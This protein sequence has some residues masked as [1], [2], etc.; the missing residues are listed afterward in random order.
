M[1][2]TDSYI[3]DDHG[4]PQRCDDLLVWAR[5]METATRVVEQTR[6]DHPFPP[7]DEQIGCFTSG[8]VCRSRDLGHA[9]TSIDLSIRVSTVFL[10]LDYGFRTDDG[11]PVLWESMIF[12]GPL[13]GEMRRYTSRADAIA[14]HAELC[15][16]VRLEI[17][18]ATTHVEGE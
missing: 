9:V 6:F 14:G 8:L 4:E 18:A 17:A 10:G 5:W 1:K 2:L 13:S 16:L 7:T 15:E 3:L 11:P 12:G